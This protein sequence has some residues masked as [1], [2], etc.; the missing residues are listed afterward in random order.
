MPRLARQCLGCGKKYDGDEAKLLAYANCCP[1]CGELLPKAKRTVT[2]FFRLTFAHEEKKLRPALKLAEKGELT[3][4]AR[5]ALVALEH[6]VRE[7]AGLKDLRGRDLMSKAFSF[8]WDRT[9][10]CFTRRP[11]IAINDLNTESQRN[12]Q[13]GIHHIAIG[14]MAGARNNLAHN[15]GGVTIGN[16][17]NLITAVVFVLHHVSSRCTRLSDIR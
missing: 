6:C 8:D 7:T 2:A 17:L 16:A 4:A 13:D 3:A 9:K 15:S 1:Y 12:E 14:L 5:E 10:R 11:I